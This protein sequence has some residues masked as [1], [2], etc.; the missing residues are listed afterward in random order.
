MNTDSQFLA[1]VFLSFI[2]IVLLVRNIMKM[3]SSKEGLCVDPIKCGSGKL[4]DLVTGLP[5]DPIQSNQPSIEPSDKYYTSNLVIS[6]QPA[7]AEKQKI[8]YFIDAN[9]VYADVDNDR[10]NKELLPRGVLFAI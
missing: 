3:N 9:R 8:N 7:N 4:V 1:G 5:Y 10:L 2:L 6:N